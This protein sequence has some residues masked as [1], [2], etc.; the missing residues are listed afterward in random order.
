MAVHV[1]EPHADFPEVVGWPP[2][3]CLQ[4]TGMTAC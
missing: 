4:G 3:R 2:T 1:D